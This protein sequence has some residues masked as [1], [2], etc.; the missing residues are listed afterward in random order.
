MNDNF[1][2]LPYLE[3]TDT[4]Q[5]LDELVADIST[6]HRKILEDWYKANL[7]KEYE[8][9][10]E[11]KPFEFTLNQKPIHDHHP[12]E[13]GRDIPCFMGYRYWFTRNNNQEKYISEEKKDGV[14]QITFADEHSGLVTDFEIHPR[15][16]RKLINTLERD[17]AEDER[18][19][20]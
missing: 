15:N 14:L 16:I 9:R 19:E 4:Q 20:E 7:A 17:L 12:Q 18:T 6:N 11:I 5:Y 2:A 13:D 10:K 8:D 1:K 3:K